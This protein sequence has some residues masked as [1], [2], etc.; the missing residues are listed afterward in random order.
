MR[1]GS[2]SRR[3]GRGAAAGCPRRPAPRG[4]PEPGRAPPWCPSPTSRAARLRAAGGRRRRSGS[5][6]T[7]TRPPRP[8]S[9]TPH[10]PPDRPA[11]SQP[12][13]TARTSDAPTQHDD[14]TPAPTGIGPGAA[15]QDTST[16]QHDTHTGTSTTHALTP[17]R[18]TTPGRTT[19]PTHRNT[20]PSGHDAR[21][22]RQSLRTSP[23][24]SARRARSWGHAPTTGATPEG[25]A[26]RRREAWSARSASQAGL[27]RSARSASQPA[28]QSHAAVGVRGRRR[29]AGPRRG[30]WTPRRSPRGR[31][32]RRRRSPSRSAAAGRGRG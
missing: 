16:P 6:I 21:R 31:S 14:D 15:W 4:C 22:V 29:C 25:G 9:P 8:E 5:R 1:R 18:A 3:A 10:R 11:A 28:A 7:S 17:P 30:R 13:T 32:G 26:G 24:R 2:G 20:R 12:G 19:A 27:R 23:R